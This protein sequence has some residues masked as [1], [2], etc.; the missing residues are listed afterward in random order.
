MEQFKKLAESDTYKKDPASETRTLPEFYAISGTVSGLSLMP[1]NIITKTVVQARR[2]NYPL[3]PSPPRL[4]QRLQ[5]TCQKLMSPR[6]IGN[7]V[8]ITIDAYPQNL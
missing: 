7:K 1:G 4:N 8:T 5:S 6:S 2:P 3:P